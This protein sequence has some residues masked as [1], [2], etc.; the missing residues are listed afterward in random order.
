MTT[1][2]RAFWEDR[3]AADWTETG[4]GYRALGRPFNTWMYRVRREVFLRE[5]GRLPVDPASADVLDVG[6]GTGFYVSLWRELGARSVTGCDLTQAAVDR[7][8]QRFPGTEFHQ[9]DIS[10]PLTALPA[11]SFDLVSCIDVLFH[12]TDDDGHRTAVRNLTR[13]VRPGG[14]VLISENFVHGREQRGPRQVNR[15]MV[16]IRAE[17]D[18]AGL[19][20]VRRAPMFVLMNAQVDAGWLRRRAW[21][22]VMRTATVLPA[23]GWATGALLYPLERRLVRRATEGPSTELAICRRPP[24]AIRGRHTADRR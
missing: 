21:A 3:L 20:M 10:E 14:C 12:I 6:S 2:S 5:V 18:D 22:A 23:T 15:S 4:V 1:S 24:A 16:R 9:V 11:E 8:R 13:L 17:L 7:L 19:E